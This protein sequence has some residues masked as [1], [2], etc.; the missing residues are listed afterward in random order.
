MSEPRAGTHLWL[1]L[2]KAHRSLERHAR[3][4]IEDMALGLSDFAILELLLHKGPQ[5][6]SE[7]GKW[8][9]LSSGAM[10]T[11][12]DRLEQR[13]LVKRAFTEDRRARLVSLTGPGRVLISKVFAAHAAAME[14][15]MSGLS[16]AEQ[17]RLAELLKKLGTTAELRFK[18]GE[19]S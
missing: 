1:V 16:A 18:G 12:V 17:A 11:A 4:S 19:R 9:E 3:R 15:A 14:H 5:K 6:V 7:I 13:K 10:T 2:M 8:I